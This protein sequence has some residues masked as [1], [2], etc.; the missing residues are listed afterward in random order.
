MPKIECSTMSTLE[1]PNEED[2]LAIVAH[3]LPTTCNDQD[4]LNMIS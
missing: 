1:M 4:T 3:A 2:L